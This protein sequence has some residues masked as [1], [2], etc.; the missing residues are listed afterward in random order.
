M[1]IVCIGGGPAGL[2][3]ALLRK[4]A[5]PEDEVRVLERNRRGDTFGWGVVFSAE[6]LGHFREHDAP[7]YESIRARFIYWDDIEVHV[8]GE[9]VRSRGHGFCG[10]SRRALLEILEDRALEL[11]VRV[12]HGVEVESERVAAEADVVVVCDGANSKL[13]ERHAAHFRPS[14][15]WRQCRFSWLGSTLPL[16]AFTFFFKENEHGLFRVHAYPFEPGT[17]TFIVECTEAC[18]RAA[19]LHEASEAQTLAYCEQLFAPELHGHRL[20]ANRSVWRAFPTVRCERWVHEKL[21]LIGDAAH[22]AHFSIGSGTKLAMEDAIALAAALEGASAEPAQVH[23]AL[24]RY[25]QGRRL[26][27]LKLQRAAQTSLEWFE[28]TERYARQHPLVFS[29]N[30]LSR[31]KRITY[32]NLRRRD[33]DFVARLDEHLGRELGGA[34]A[35]DGRMPP[36]A[37]CPIEL[38]GLRLENRIVVSPMCQ[39]NA[40]EGVPGDWQLVHLGSRALGGAGLVITEMTNVSADGR[41]TPAC[42]GLWNETQSAAWKRIVDF[43]H[44]HS[45]ARI[46]VQLAHAGRKGS[47]EHP[48]K[49]PDRPLEQGGWTTLAPS[50]LPYDRAWPAPRAMQRADFERVRADF[51]RATRLALA[52]G[53]DLIELHLAHGYLL[54]SFLSPLSNRREDEYGGSLENRMRFPLEVVAAVRAAWLHDRPL[55][56]RISATDWVEPEGVTIEEAIVLARAL[57]AA[58]CALVDVSTAGNDLRSRPIYGR[59]Y[60]VP[61]ADAIR[62]ATGMTVMAVGGIQGADHANTVIAAGRADLAALARPHL[63]DPYL[64]LHAA[65]RYG[66]AARW[67]GP[68]LP[69]SAAPSAES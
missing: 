2:Y 47:V 20:L 58:G 18:W 39:Y 35:D 17:S 43:V 63:Y 34:R 45:A 68:Y 69:G 28:H 65:A 23:A 19:G 44:Q 31:S 9:R 53:F 32:D 33:P 8:Q 27:V 38:D 26:D 10:L 62:H 36:P 21:V 61:Y 14:I 16:D 1:K 40:S 12:E 64:A 25:E 37:F 50:A 55:A 22:T 54:S 7:S 52:A 5:H 59:M 6:T 13:R 66:V 29:F 30:L 57:R 51:V 46:G 4:R 3:F 24:E 67:P 48:W 41:I 49:G 42:A 56:A 11:G 15:D 60:Q